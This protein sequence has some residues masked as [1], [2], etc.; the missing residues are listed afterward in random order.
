MINVKRIFGEK[1]ILTE[2]FPGQVE[3]KQELKDT[4]AKPCLCRMP[5]LPNHSTFHTNLYLSIYFSASSS[6]PE[7]P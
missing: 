5:V 2:C 6:K 7:D 1:A 3:W 4:E